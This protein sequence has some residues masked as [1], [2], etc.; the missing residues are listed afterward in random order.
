MTENILKDKIP[1]SARDSTIIESEFSIQKYIRNE[2]DH[3]YYINLA[4]SIL[5]STQDGPLNFLLQVNFLCLYKNALVLRI[6]FFFKSLKNHWFESNLICEEI[7]TLV[8]SKYIEAVEKFN[9]IFDK[10]DDRH[11]DRKLTS[12]PDHY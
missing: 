7:K 3:I 8:G 1:H 9:N 6:L 2:H 11:E 10:Y 4:N 12:T 5:I